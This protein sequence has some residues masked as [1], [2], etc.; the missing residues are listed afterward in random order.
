MTA[1][2]HFHCT[3]TGAEGDM[4]LYFWLNLT[5][6]HGIYEIAEVPGTGRVWTRPA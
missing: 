5:N 2:F 6:P 3:A 4:T 1:S